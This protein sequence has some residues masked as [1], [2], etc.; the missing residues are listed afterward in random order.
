MFLATRRMRLAL[1]PGGSG[2]YALQVQTP[3]GMVT[4]RSFSTGKSKNSR[5]FSG[6]A[7]PQAAQARTD[8][9]VNNDI[10]VE[11]G[12]DIGNTLKF[13]HIHLYVD[14]LAELEE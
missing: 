3:F 4:A 8:Q 6:A 11:M 2:A 1:S 5:S 9:Y 12:A 7:A 13:H 14:S 10:K